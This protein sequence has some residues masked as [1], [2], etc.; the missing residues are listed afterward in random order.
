M[1][2]NEKLYEKAKEAI[3]EL[4][5]DLSVSRATAREN[6]EAL[7]GDIDA[8]LDCLQDNSEDGSDG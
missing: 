4:F 1:T 3:G 7:K 5:S 2:D 8:F 6:L